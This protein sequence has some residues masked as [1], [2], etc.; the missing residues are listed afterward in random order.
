METINVLQQLPGRQ[1]Q[2]MLRLAGPHRA[3]M[4]APHDRSNSPGLFRARMV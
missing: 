3:P 4:N 2:L 1:K